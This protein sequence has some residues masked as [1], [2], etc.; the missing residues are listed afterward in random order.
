MVAVV[1]GDT[2]GYSTNGA[3]LITYTQAVVTAGSIG[4]VSTSGVTS[5]IYSNPAAFQAA[6]DYTTPAVSTQIA[7]AVVSASGAVTGTPWLAYSA[8]S[9]LPPPATGGTCS[10]PYNVSAPA[11]DQQFSLTP[12]GAVTIV[13]PIA[14]FATNRH[15][16]VPFK[17]YCGAHQITWDT[18]TIYSNSCTL[19]TNKINGLVI[20]RFEGQTNAWV[21]GAPW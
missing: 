11:W 15:W 9:N 19:S 16:A 4:A 1:S 20:T 18:A 2:A 13:F 12:T 14:D 10:I 17:L 3:G 21:T 5:I 8:S 7:Q 6:G